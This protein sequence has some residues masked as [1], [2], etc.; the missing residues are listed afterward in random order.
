MKNY[1]PPP[2][3]ANDAEGQV[4]KWNAPK[5]PKSPEETN[6]ANELKAYETQVVE[7]EGQAEGA[8]GAGEE[9]WFVEDEEGAPA[10]GGH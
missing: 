4:S 7:T 5:P 6:I 2:L 8:A 10:A 1:K 9:D 3:A